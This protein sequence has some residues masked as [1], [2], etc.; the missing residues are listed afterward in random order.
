MTIP[1]PFDPDGF[2]Y[3]IGGIVVGVLISAILESI[4]ERIQ[5]WKKRMEKSPVKDLDNIIKEI[6]E[7]V[8]KNMQNSPSSILPGILPGQT[9]NNWGPEILSSDH[10]Y[11]IPLPQPGIIT[12]PI[13]RLKNGRF[14]KKPKGK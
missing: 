8:Q 5:K 2:L 1:A 11:Q 10:K 12:I 14:A 13:R 7:E 6:K 4:D 9:I 3:F